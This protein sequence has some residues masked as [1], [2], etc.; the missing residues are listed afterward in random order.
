[1]L[2]FPHPL[3]TDDDG[4]L[5]IGGDLSAPRLL[6]AYSSGIFPWYNNGPILWWF[7]HP[8]AVIFPGEVKISKSM[9][10]LVFSKRPWRLSMNQAFEEVIDSCAKAK[11]KGQADTWINKDILRAFK[12][13]HSKGIV[14]SIEVWENDNLIGGLYGLA[15]GRI[16][17]GESMFSLKSNTSKYA[18]IHLCQY[19]DY[20]GFIL[21]D[22]QQDTDHMI[23]LGSKLISKENFW[24]IIKMNNLENTIEV[25]NSS[26]QQWLASTFSNELN[27]N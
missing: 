4:L 26:F 15:I 9:R 13:L 27:V 1:M 7:T 6:L 19:L 12:V 25:S 3:T 5:A 18:F 17:F 11:R 21:V 23:S 20:M 16:F 24:K 10:G 14:H 2:Y 8:R 22:C